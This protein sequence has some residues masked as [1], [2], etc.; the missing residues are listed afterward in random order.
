M[1]AP[2]HNQYPYSMPSTLT[3]DESEDNPDGYFDTSEINRTYEQAYCNELGCF[4]EPV[5][6]GFC[7]EH[8]EPAHIETFGRC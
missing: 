3:D 1:L 2:A 6:D 5:D 4:N 8:A 7:D